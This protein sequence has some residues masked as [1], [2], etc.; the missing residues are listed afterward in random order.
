MFERVRK[1]LKAKLVLLLFGLNMSVILLVGIFSYNS[2]RTALINQLDDNLTVISRQT[3]ENV[4]RFLAERMSDTRAIALHYSLFNLKTT[5]SSQNTVLARYLGIYP[6]YEHISIINISD[7]RAPAGQEEPWYLPAMRGQVTCSDIYMS[8]LT[9]RPTLSFAAPV[10]DETGKVVSIMTTNLKISYLWDIV[11]KVG[12]ENKKNRLSGYA[13][14]LNRKGIIIGHPN[15]SKILTEDL[16]K[17]TDAGLRA[18]VANM[19]KGSSGTSTYWY[20][21][22]DK[23]VAYAPCTGFG[24]F[25]GNGWSIG[26]TYP[27]VE[28][29]APLKRLVHTY[30]MI[31]MA[32]SILMLL[33][34]T[35]LANYLVKPILAL[36]RGAGKVG[37]G[38]FGMRID[39]AS[40]DELG[41]LAGSFNEMAGTLHAREEQIMEYTRTLTGINSELNT[42][43]EEISR[44]NEVL[45]QTNQELMKLQQQKAEFL[46]MLTHDIKSPLS[47]IIMYAELIMTGVMPSGGESLEK[48]MGGIHSS[49]YKI[50]S[51][52]DN[53]LV[54]SAIEAGKLQVNLA[55]LDINDF[56]DD[57]LPLLTPRMEKRNISFTFNRTIPLP[58]VL[59]D[60][61]QLDRVVNNLVS[62][63]IKFT[64]PGGSITLT[65]GI[66][67]RRVFIAVKDTGSG[68]S[69]AE[70][71]ELFQMFKRS[72]GAS[73][74][75]GFGLGLYISKA[76]AEAHNGEITVAS[77]P[78][79]GSTFT[80][81]IPAAK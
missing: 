35:Q 25:A 55:R 19:M 27:V 57:E 11:D 15:R 37:G 70:Q 59:A 32:T 61:V 20:E 24:D 68:I 65:T 58:P 45:V 33:I 44:A 80:V 3:A 21:G 28:Q 17:N 56:L 64:Q 7:V 41:E 14:M 12:N 54:S 4:D 43:Q 73:K 22:L 62:N 81:Y 10:K 67:G 26:V 75:K 79:E 1:S 47:T 48:A 30:L 23:F 9:D 49:G 52:V 2:T 18:T 6:Y 29:F 16:S 74:V 78:G 60:K 72:S 76:I 46:A 42:K 13:F 77:N 38:D 40:S 63:A 34:S 69:E 51:L 71:A 31:F 66:E 36:K 53:F 8:P 50:L 39:V 5:T